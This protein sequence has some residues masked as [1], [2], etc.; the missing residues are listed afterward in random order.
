DGALEVGQEVELQPGRL[1]ARI[2]GLQRHKTKV[3]RLEPG[4]RAAVNLSGVRA[5]ELS[6]GMV[7]SLPGVI[8]PVRVVDVLLRAPDILAHPLQHDAGVTFLAA[9]SETEAKLRLLDRDALLPGEE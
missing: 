8:A 4:T 1:R 3:D 5:E 6:R 7:L 9:T 2:R